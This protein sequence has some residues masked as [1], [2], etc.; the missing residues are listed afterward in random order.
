MLTTPTR[1]ILHLSD[2]HILPSADD[3]SHGVDTM[4][5]LR[6][7]VGRVIQSAVKPDAIVVSGDLANA[8]ELDSYQRLRSVLDEMRDY[9]GVPVLPA[10]GNHDKRAAFREALLGEPPS[11]APYDNV[12]WVGGL[13]VV[14]LDSTVP[15]FPYGELEVAQLAWLK[16]VLAEPA[17]EGT[18]VVLHHPPIPDPVPVIN[19]LLLRNAD[20]LAAA[21]ENSDVLAVLT[22]HAHHPI[23]GMFAGRLCFSAPA[24]AYTVDALVADNRLRGVEGPGF[25]LV[26]IYDRTVVGSAIHLPADARELYEEQIDEEVLRRWGV[27]ASGLR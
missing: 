23:A 18:L 4:Q 24:T 7:A 16:N 15:G 26:Q 10:M 20:A 25:G 2:T 14:V 13:R 22:G 21:I 27:V 12:A 9:F 6:S 5:T 3:R 17:S 11:D 1:T 8:G 19:L